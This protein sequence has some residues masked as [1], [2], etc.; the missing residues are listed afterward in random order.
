[1]GASDFLHVEKLRQKLH[2]WAFAKCNEIED[3][4]LTHTEKTGRFDEIALH[5]ACDRF[6]RWQGVCR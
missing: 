6:A 4:S 3:I 2:Q 5:L 1:M